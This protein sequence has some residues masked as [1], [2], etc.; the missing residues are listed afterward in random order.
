MRAAQDRH[1][2][3]EQQPGSVPRRPTS[4]LTNVDLQSNLN[5]LEEGYNSCNNDNLR[6]FQGRYARPL[7]SQRSALQL[8]GG[9]SPSD[10]FCT[11]PAS[12]ESNH[13]FESS[14]PRLNLKNFSMAPESDCV[15]PIFQN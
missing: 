10:S 8:E 1:L 5:P 12:Q 11:D 4:K 13:N 2:I 7:D 15:F 3:E 14:P 9:D 6:G